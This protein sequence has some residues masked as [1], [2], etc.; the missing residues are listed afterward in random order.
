MNYMKQVAKMLGVEL[1]QEFI[2]KNNNETYKL[3][4]DGLLHRSTYFEEW[5]R[6][7]LTLEWL[8]TGKLK[9]IKKFKVQEQENIK[10][11]LKA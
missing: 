3:S 4:E 6:E 11:D 1:E 9:I 10:G 5:D 8:I 2:V 7:P